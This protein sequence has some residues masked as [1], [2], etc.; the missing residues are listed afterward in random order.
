MHWK[1][2]MVVLVASAGW[3]A[4]KGPDLYV[5]PAVS[6][7][8]EAE[9]TQSEAEPEPDRRF[10]GARAAVMQL[11]SLLSAKRFDEALELMSYETRDA[12]A[13]SSPNGQPDTALATGRLHLSGGRE[14]A[15]NPVDYLLAED[16]SDLRPAIEGVEVH[17]T[18]RRKVVFAVQPLGEIRQIVMIKEGDQWVLHR[19]TFR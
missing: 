18:E 1:W 7:V 3:I 9:P 5:L 15:F 4:C 17:E 8:E 2:L 14:V 6:G 16:V 19:V 13:I 11:H 10:E 12:L